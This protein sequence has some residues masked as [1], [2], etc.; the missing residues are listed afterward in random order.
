GASGTPLL[1]ETRTLEVTAGRNVYLTNS[2]DLHAL[3]L[4]VRHASSGAQNVYDIRSEALTFALTD[5]N[6]GSQYTLGSV[7]DASGL[8]FS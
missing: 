3:S 6:T 4:D 1:T 5:S 7:V 8:D 2:A